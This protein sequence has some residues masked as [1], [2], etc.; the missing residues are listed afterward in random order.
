MMWAVI[1]IVAFGLVLN[2]FLI[3]KVND[4]VNSVSVDSQIESSQAKAIAL[5]VDR[6]LDDT[7]K[8]ANS[9]D[10]TLA[11]KLAKADQ[12]INEIIAKMEYLAKTIEKVDAD[13]KEIRSYYINYRDPVKPNTGVPWAESVKTSDEIYD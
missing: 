2:A 12:Q 7:I 3:H 4:K 6:R 5:S 9:N 13:E 8:V 10:T 11:N 1:I